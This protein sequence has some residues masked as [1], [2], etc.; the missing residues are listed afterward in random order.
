[1][2]DALN[3]DAINQLRDVSWRSV[4][5]NLIIRNLSMPHD[6]AN[7]MLMYCPANR[8]MCEYK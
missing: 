1:M 8:G 5:Q 2:R 3:G 7:E 4:N 6:E